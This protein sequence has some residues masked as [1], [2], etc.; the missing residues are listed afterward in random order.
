MSH[1]SDVQPSQLKILITNIVFD[2]YTGTEI[3]VRDLA[4]ELKRQGHQP[5]IF[6][7]KLGPISRE[8]QHLDVEVSSDLASLRTVPDIIHGHHHPPFIE[9]LLRFPGVPAVSVCHDATSRHDEPFHYPRILR[10]VAVDERCRKRVEKTAGIPLSRITVILNAVDLERFRGREPLPSKPKRAL[11]FSNQTGQVP[12]IRSAARRMGL[13]LQV[14]G[15]GA[16]N[17]IPN[18]ESMLPHYDI[19]FAKARCAL[20][21]MA[22]GN[23]VVLC[24]CG[25]CG[26]MVTSENFDRLRSMNFGQGVLL[27]P[28]QRTHIEAQIERYNCD[29]ATAVSQRV[30]VEAGLRS[31]TQHWL[32]LYADVL[33]EFRETNIG[34]A[35]EFSALSD[36]LH[37]WN[38][39]ARVDWEREQLQRLQ[40]VPLVGNNLLPLGKRVLTWW[41]DRESRSSAKC[42]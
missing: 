1:P 36:Y 40:T 22:V 32:A 29:D 24:D 35:S 41:K 2:G 34:S 19:V 13:E 18:P 39:E 14:L 16:G 6:S 37:Q 31:A 25:G 42:F 12:A 5:F 7:R 28:L 20:E 30:R 27:N 17:A 26:P 9:A 11:I 8:V 23:A 4:S 10:Y 15:L 3:V 21:A 33:A 38:Y